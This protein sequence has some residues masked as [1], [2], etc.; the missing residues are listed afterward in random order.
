MREGGEQGVGNL[1]GSGEYF[2]SSSFSNSDSDAFILSIQIFI[3]PA[4]ERK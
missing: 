1:T 4:E 2:F 3:K